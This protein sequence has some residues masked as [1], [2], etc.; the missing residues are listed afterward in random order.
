MLPDKNL[1]DARFIDVGSVDELPKKGFIIRQAD[2]VSIVLCRIQDEI[3]AVENRCSHA[4]QTFE[5][6]RLRGVRLMCP[7]HGA[8][9]DVRDGKALGLPATSPIKSFIVRIDGDRI[10]IDVGDSFD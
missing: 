10:R 9:F 1:A 3:Y 7:R 5:D 2:G 4:F 8:C 6:G